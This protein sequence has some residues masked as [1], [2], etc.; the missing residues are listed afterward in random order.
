MTHKTYAHSCHRKRKQDTL[1]HL[2]KT[3]QCRGV[4]HT[5]IC[6][7]ENENR[8]PYGIYEKLHQCRGVLHTPI[9]V[10]ENENRTPYG[11]YKKHHHVGAYC[12]RPLVTRKRIY[13]A[14]RHLQKTPPM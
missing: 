4:L 5:P 2:R 12:I 3:H 10:T 7:T 14:L 11:I 6:V 13:D 9:C 1:R 8:T